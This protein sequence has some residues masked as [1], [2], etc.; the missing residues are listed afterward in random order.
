MVSSTELSSDLLSDVIIVDI[1]Q[2]VQINSMSLY[3]LSST[4]VRTADL[5]V[6][7]LAELRMCQCF[8][9]R[10][11]NNN[12]YQDI[13]MYIVILKLLGNQSFQQIRKL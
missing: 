2:D 11:E 12:P 6:R 4:N 10:P 5:G 13:C 7:P 3:C 9:K 1:D 8:E